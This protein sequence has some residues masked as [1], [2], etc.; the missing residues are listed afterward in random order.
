MLLA[1]LRVVL[2]YIGSWGE[3]YGVPESGH[4]IPLS[5]CTKTRR[6]CL[7]CGRKCGRM[8]ISA[9]VQ[10]KYTQAEELYTQGKNWNRTLLFCAFLLFCNR[11]SLDQSINS[12]SS[13]YPYMQTHTYT[14][15]TSLPLHFSP[16]LP[17]IMFHLLW[18]LLSSP[19]SLASGS[20]THFLSLFFPSTVLNTVPND[21]IRFFH[22]T[23][24]RV[25]SNLSN[26]HGL[27]CW[28]KQGTE[29]ETK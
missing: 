27:R 26:W 28:W 21:V 15:F 7:V 23:I 22:S 10:P 18:F 9:A 12:A 3:R 2:L 1:A 19:C 24:P 4:K 11:T 16:F 20:R 13:S 25:L 8:K 29:H 14:V 5:Y 17:R 6:L